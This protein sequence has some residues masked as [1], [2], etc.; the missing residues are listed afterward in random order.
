MS[1]PSV[2]ARLR[3]RSGVASIVLAGI[4]CRALI[5]AGFMPAAIADGGPVAVCHGGI[6]GEFFRRLSAAHN[7]AGQREAQSAQ[8][9]HGA[10][11]AR[12]V[13]AGHGAPAGA[14]L[15]TGHDG[16]D[17]HAAAA[18]QDSPAAHESLADHEPHEDSAGAAHEAWEHCPVGASFAAA[19]V[20]AEFSIALL[21][22]DHVFLHTEPALPAPVAPVF[23]YRARAPPIPLLLS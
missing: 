12:V 4:V 21:D 16:H 11:V 17:G 6:A 20:S 7:A 9:G 23:S 15:H 3:R 10:D 22:L 5:P 13:H 2:M 8:H 14:E 18:A 19:A 1:S